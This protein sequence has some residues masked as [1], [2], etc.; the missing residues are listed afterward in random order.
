MGWIEFTRWI[1]DDNSLVVAGVH[2]PS[3]VIEN[4]Q[5]WFEKDGIPTKIERRSG[6]R[7]LFRWMEDE[8]LVE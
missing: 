8:Q 7:A 6:G 2:I 4:W 5:R 1:P 3:F